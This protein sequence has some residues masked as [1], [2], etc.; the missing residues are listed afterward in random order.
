MCAY[1]SEKKAAEEKRLEEERKLA[2][3]AA[4]RAKIQGI[5]EEL[6]CKFQNVCNL[7]FIS[8]TRSFHQSVLGLKPLLG[9]IN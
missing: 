8:L 1:F 9:M 3:I 6:S 4:E 7:M 5:I 2:E